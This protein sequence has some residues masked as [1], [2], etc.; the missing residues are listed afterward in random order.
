MENIKFKFH[1]D[2]KNNKRIKNEQ[3]NAELIIEVTPESLQNTIL[4]ETG[5][6]NILTTMYS[7]LL[8]DGP[9]FSIYVKKSN[10]LI[11]ARKERSIGG[12]T[13]IKVHQILDSKLYINTGIFTHEI[14]EFLERWL[15]NL[16]YGKV[17]LIF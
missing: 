5:V 6:K 12:K 13:L 3:D 1:N 7:L 15:K 8:N 17:F 16:A 4:S 10:A 11:L 14:E 2:D 9:E